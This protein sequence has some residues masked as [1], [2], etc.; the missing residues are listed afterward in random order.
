MS[1]YLIV[2]EDKLNGQEYSIPVDSIICVVDAT[3]E[4]QEPK[5]DIYYKQLSIQTNVEGNVVRN[6]TRTRIQALKYRGTAE[7]FKGTICEAIMKSMAEP[8]SLN[9]L[10]FARFDE[11]GQFIQVIQPYPQ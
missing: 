3:G 6:L 2:P 4:D 1:N 9:E 5:I 11:N 10:I 7:Q 8:N